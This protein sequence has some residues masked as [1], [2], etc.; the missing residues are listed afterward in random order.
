MQL[1]NVVK[2]FTLT[3]EDGTQRQFALGKQMLDEVLAGHWYVKAHLGEAPD[4]EEGPEAQGLATLDEMEADL[5]AAQAKFEQEKAAADVDLAARVK[6]V[7]EAETA[8]NDAQA[9]LVADRAA[10]EQE[11]AAFEA[12]RQPADAADTKAEAAQPAKKK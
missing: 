2:S 10:L 11:R 6:A 3:L 8:L 1:V 12:A 9:K 4:A 7:A 5:K